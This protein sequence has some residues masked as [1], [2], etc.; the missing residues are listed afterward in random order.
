LKTRTSVSGNWSIVLIY[1]KDGPAE[2]I[3][4]HEAPGGARLEYPQEAVEEVMVRGAKAYLVYG[5]FLLPQKT[6][7]Y[8]S[9]T[10]S[11]AAVTYSLTISDG[12]T[13]I[14][15]HGMGLQLIF[16]LDGW[17]VCY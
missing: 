8:T 10:D 2:E 1:H 5:T 11:S 15:N 3:W 17:V 4:I 6:A 14:W 12:S 9:T 16:S 13:L 7:T